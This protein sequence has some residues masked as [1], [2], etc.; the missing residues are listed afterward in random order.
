MTPRPLARTRRAALALAVVGLISMAGCDPRSLFYFLQP[1]DP[2]ISAPAPSLK[3]KRVVVITRA[4]A[5][6]QGEFLTLDREIT[7][8]LAK[9]LRKNVK[10][11]D[12]VD[13]EKVFTWDQAHP[14]WTDPAAVAEVFGAD[15]VIF[16]EIQQFQISSPLSPDMF[17]GKSSIHVQVTELQYPKDSRGREMKD[18]AREPTVSF[19]ETKETTFPIRGPMPME[20]GVSRTSF[21]NKFLKLVITEVSW[22]FVDHAPGDSVQDT[23]FTPE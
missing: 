12:V 10:K 13:P 1:F 4:A 16:L 9:I 22:F 15:A 8:E 7:R 2:T 14:D 17:E 23:R 18:K 20:T 5:G 11:I 6:T 3:G 19:E 21:R